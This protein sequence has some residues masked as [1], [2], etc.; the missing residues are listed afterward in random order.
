MDEFVKETTKEDAEPLKLP[1]G[2]EK[3]F[4]KYF[5]LFLQTELGI[6]YLKAQDIILD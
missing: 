1:I 4:E 6:E 2:D 3:T 5:K